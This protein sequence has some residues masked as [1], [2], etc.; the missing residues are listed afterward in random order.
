MIVKV[1]VLFWKVSVSPHQCSGAHVTVQS[2]LLSVSF[3]HHFA[4]IAYK[5]QHILGGPFC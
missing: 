3:S 2:S 5:Q 4:L 1:F